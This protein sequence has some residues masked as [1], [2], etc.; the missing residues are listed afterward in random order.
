MI[1]FIFNM[2][3]T[4]VVIFQGLAAHQL[5]Q[6]FWDDL[7]RQTIRVPQRIQD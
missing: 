4:P 7:P 6:L 5:T 2:A 3:C 1:F